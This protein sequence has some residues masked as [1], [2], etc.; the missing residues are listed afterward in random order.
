M[1]DSYKP[2]S[3]FYDMLSNCYSFGRIARCRSAYVVE[4]ANEVK[5]RDPGEVTICFAGVGHGDE[6]I[7]V[8]GQGAMVTVVDISESMLDV[9]Q[10][11]LSRVPAAVRNR[12]T[13]IHDDIRNVPHRYDWVI[14]NFFLN[15]FSESEMTAMLDVLL[16]KIENQGKLVIGDFLCD[17]GRSCLLNDLQQANWYLALLV[18]RILV[19]NAKHPIYSYEQYLTK[20]GWHRKDSKK[21]GILGVSFYSSSLYGQLNV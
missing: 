17:H 6:A 7:A 4:M 10:K 5:R 15:V 21:F 2:V 9:F 3:K 18:F 8:A 11:K 16:V 19:K 12:M 13:I 20:R 14:A 1:S